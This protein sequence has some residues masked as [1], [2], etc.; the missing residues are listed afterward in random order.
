[1][2]E[3]GPAQD[4]LRHPNTRP[5]DANVR[6]KNQIALN[7]RPDPVPADQAGERCKRTASHPPEKFVMFAGW[8]PS[9]GLRETASKI[10]IEISGPP[11][12]ARLADFVTYWEGDGAAYNQI[13]WEMKLACSLKNQLQRAPDQVLAIRSAGYDVED[14]RVI[15]ETISGSAHAMQRREFKNV[16][17]HK[18]EPGDSL[19]VQKVDRLGCD[20]IDVLSTVKMLEERGIRIICLDLPCPDLSTAQGK[21]MLGLF[22]VFA[23]WKRDKII[24]RPREGLNRVRKEGKTL[25]RPVADKTARFVQELKKKD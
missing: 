10:G 2:A 20:A 24:E 23:A 18:L 19:V 14:Y 17:E 9:S 22:S 12:P 1:M 8:Q 7:L 25:G 15:S 4:E 13:Q 3:Y 5:D 6:L 11:D 21:L 16:V